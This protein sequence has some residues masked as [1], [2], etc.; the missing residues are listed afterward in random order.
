MIKSIC[1]IGITLAICL[2]FSG[3]SYAQ[4]ND[5]TLAFHRKKIDS[6]DQKLIAVL[7]E[8]ERV[9]KEVGIYK[10]KNNI[11]ALQK[12]RFKQILE[13]NIKMGA[14]GGLS[15]KLI[16]KVMNAIHEE[17]LRIERAVKKEETP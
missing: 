8:R 11:P 2:L 13:K 5:P 4:S 10:M 1:S 14:E 3:I 15:A 6:L 7:A 12:G 9:V 17:S 16:T